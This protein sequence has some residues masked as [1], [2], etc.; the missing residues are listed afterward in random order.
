MRRLKRTSTNRNNNQELD[1]QQL[2]NDTYNNNSNNNNKNN[3]N[4]DPYARDECVLQPGVRRTQYCTYT[5]TFPRKA[6]HVCFSQFSRPSNGVVPYDS[7]LFE[8]LPAP[9]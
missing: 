8:R 5:M 2:T 6:K 1:N 4:H 3:H 7:H 9:A